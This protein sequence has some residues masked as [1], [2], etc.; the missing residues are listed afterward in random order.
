VINAEYSF[1]LPIAP[2]AAFSYFSNPENDPEWQDSC[3]E[4]KMLDGSPQV[5]AHYNIVFSFLGRKMQFKALI[6]ESDAL[7]GV[8]GFR[9]VEGPFK[10]EG[11]YAFHPHPEGSRVDWRFDAEPGGFFG[12]LP[13]GLIKK[14]LISQ[15][16]KDSGKLRKRLLAANAQAATV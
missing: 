3:V 10:Y 15:V 4:C 16:E 11:R 12:I 6:V 2:E 13:I 7:R 9:V 8:Y 14:V 5:G 1:T